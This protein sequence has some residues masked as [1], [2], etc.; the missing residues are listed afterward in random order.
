MIRPKKTDLF[1]LWRPPC[2]VRG[3]QRL[4][5]VV[6]I[7]PSVTAQVG[8]RLVGKELRRSICIDLSDEVIAAALTLCSKSTRPEVLLDLLPS[9]ELSGLL[10]EQFEESQ[11]LTLE[12]VPRPVA[13]ANVG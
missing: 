8:R 13:G 11:R 4:H 5:L 12:A 9:E 1:L 6:I 2:A 10:Q 7:G 3:S